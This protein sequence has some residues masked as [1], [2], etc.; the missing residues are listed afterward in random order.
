MSCRLAL[1]GLLFGLVAGA[2]DWVDLGDEGRTLYVQ[3]QAVAP[4]L[5]TV[6]GIQLATGV[7]HGQIRVECLKIATHAKRQPDELFLLA[8]PEL[9]AAEPAQDDAWT[10][11]NRRGWSDANLAAVRLVGEA[12]SPE[13]VRVSATWAGLATAE[14]VSAKLLRVVDSPLAVTNLDPPDP[15]RNP[16]SGLMLDLPGAGTDPFRIDFAV[17]PVLDAE[18]GVVSASATG[19]SW[20]REQIDAGRGPVLDRPADWNFRLHSY[21]AFHAGRFWAMWSHGPRIEDFPSQ[22]VRFSTSQDGL[23]WSPSRLVVGPAPHPFRYISRGFWVRDGKLLALASRDE[24]YRFFGPSLE[25][26]AFAWDQGRDAWEDAG[27]V[28]PDAINN[29]PPKQLADGRWLMSRRDHKMNKSMLIGGNEGLD[30]WAVS[31]VAVPEDGAK[32]EEPFWWRLPDGNLVALF[33]DNSGSK[34]LY[35]ADELPRRH[36]QVQRSA[37]V[38]WSLRARQQRQSGRAQPV[39]RVRIAGWHGVHGH[40]PPAL[41]RA[42]NLPISA[43]DRARW[44]CIHYLLP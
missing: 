33:R 39:V 29:F 21:L 37:H 22:H 36:E 43:H 4:P 15:A 19:V 12:I 32:L 7:K 25:L 18:H 10:L 27:Q 6:A 9:P 1:F 13:S 23:T 20:T 8:V 26:R 40:G 28:F 38:A 44:F 24:A 16:E 14:P 11:V 31:P 35:C 2:A 42:R 5:G 17:L 41:A 34:R 30:R 3:A